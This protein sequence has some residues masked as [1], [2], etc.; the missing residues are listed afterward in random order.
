[1]A[2]GI[3]MISNYVVG[4]KKS[5]SGIIDYYERYE[6]KKG[7]N[8]IDISEIE[9]IEQ[10][11]DDDE[12]LLSKKEK[13]LL[14]DYEEYKHQGGNDDVIVYINKNQKSKEIS[15]G[16]YINYMNKDIKSSGLFGEHSNHFSFEEKINMKD[17]FNKGQQ[18]GSVLWGNVYSFD[19]EFLK[20][21]N[22]YDPKT[23]YLNEIRI[24]EA[25]RESIRVMMKEENLD[26]NAV[27]CGEIHYDTDNIHVHTSIVEMENSRPMVSIEKMRKIDSKTYEPTGEFEIQPKAKIKQKTIDKMKSTFANRLV[28]RTKDL[29][30]ISDLRKDLHHSIDISKENKKQKIILDEIKKELPINKKD[31]NYNSDAMKKVKGKIDEYTIN[32]LNLYH[33]EEFDEFKN[34]LNKE[35]EWYKELYG[36]GKE[37]RYKDYSKNKLDELKSKMGNELLREIKKEEKSATY[38]KYDNKDFKKYIDQKKSFKMI[39]K[40][41]Y[42]KKYQKNNENDKQLFREAKTNLFKLNNAVKKTFRTEKKN[43]EL[44]RDYEQM[45]QNIERDLQRQNYEINR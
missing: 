13:A 7:N 30:L 33:K 36:E 45:Q 10:A 19:N 3:V 12:I 2:P 39:S 31:W 32:H 1:M 43:H 4:S 37:D 24:K 9:R 16:N 20:K 28:D 17:M 25:V 21:H 15:Y 27:W 23:G 41:D 11:I 35:E 42:A 38:E 14:K 6:N 18:N 26:S 34:L 5:F 8:L 40:D 29:S 22:L 44:Q